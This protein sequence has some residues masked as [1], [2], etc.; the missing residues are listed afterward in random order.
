MTERELFEE[1]MR[2]SPYEWGDEV[3]DRWPNDPSKFG[4][5]DAYKNYF[6][7]LAWDVWQD[8]RKTK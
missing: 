5:P 1:N 2:A 8:A 3:L 7:R 6:A 4:W